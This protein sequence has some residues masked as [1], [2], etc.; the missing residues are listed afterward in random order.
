[1]HRA[2]LLPSKQEWTQGTS[3]VGT[4]SKA[5][6]LE[7]WGHAHM[8]PIACLAIGGDLEGKHAC[9]HACAHEGHKGLWPCEW[10][11]R[12]P[13]PR[14][15]FKQGPPLKE[16]RGSPS[17]SSFLKM[18]SLSLSSFPQIGL[19]P[20]LLQVDTLFSLTWLEWGQCLVNN[21]PSLLLRW[22]TL[23]LAFKAPISFPPRLLLNDD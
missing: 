7:G 19:P 16:K 18:G 9:T 1:M 20:S 21:E 8:A 13:P 15:K 10:G 22:H 2:R 17:L 11:L 5:L 4:N 23:S 6:A 12:P 3:S 14:T